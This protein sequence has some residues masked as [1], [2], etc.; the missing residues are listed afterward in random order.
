MIIG[1]PVERVTRYFQSLLV[2]HAVPFIVAPYSAAAQVS[3]T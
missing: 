2:Q 3:P 1:Y